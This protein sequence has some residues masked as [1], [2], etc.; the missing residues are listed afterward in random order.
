MR[1]SRPGL[2]VGRRG[3]RRRSPRHPPPAPVAAS[4]DEVVAV[5]DLVAVFRRWPS[6]TRSSDGSPRA[7]RSGY[8]ELAGDLDPLSVAT[9]S[10]PESPESSRRTGHQRQRGG[11][12][13]RG[14]SRSSTHG[15]ASFGIVEVWRRRRTKLHPIPATWERPKVP[16]HMLAMS[17][18]T[19]RRRHG[20]GPYSTVR[21]AWSLSL[22]ASTPIDGE[23]GVSPGHA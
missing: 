18:S 17:F 15:K 9:T 20:T 12:E 23:V 19:S 14:Q 5:L 1:S 11:Q 4:R 6:T 7:G 21:C 13:Q 3:C 16:R 22:R 8:A 10:S 2:L